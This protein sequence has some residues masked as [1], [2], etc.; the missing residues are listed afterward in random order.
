[1]DTLPF[2]T[3]TYSVYLL[4]FAVAAAGCLAGAWQARRQVSLPGVRRGLIGLLLTSGLWALCHVGMLLSP[5]LS[6]K[7]ALYEAGL[8]LGFGTVWAWLWLCSAYSGRALH[9]RAGVRW[10]A[11]AVFVAV[12]L[13]KMTNSWHGLYFTAGWGPEPFRHLAV[14]HHVVYWLTTALSYALAAVGFFM[15]AEP[16]RRAQVGGGKLAGLF[17]LTALPLGANAIGYATPYLLYQLPIIT[18]H[19]QPPAGSCIRSGTPLP[20]WCNCEGPSGSLVA[21]SI[22]AR[23]SRRPT[24]LSG[25]ARAARLD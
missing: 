12:T 4:I 25:P 2:G 22:N 19:L 13:T 9:R 10:A 3:P 1:M 11:L 16:L 8:T 7:T 24:G 14:D 18:I 23:R 21:G 6:L 15:L 17:A 5:G 20:H